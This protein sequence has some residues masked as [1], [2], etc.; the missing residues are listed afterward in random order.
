M[1]L[2]EA[3][4]KDWKVTGTDREIVDRWNAR[5]TLKQEVAIPVALGMSFVFETIS[6]AYLSNGIACVDVS[7]W[8]QVPLHSVSPLKS[9]LSI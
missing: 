6:N 2:A 9:G 7:I 8:G 5:F 3:V 4:I 1:Q